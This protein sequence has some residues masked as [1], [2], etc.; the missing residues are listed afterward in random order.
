MS[1]TRRM[2]EKNGTAVVSEYE[3]SEKTRRTKRNPNGSSAILPPANRP[4]NLPALPSTAT[5]DPSGSP[6]RPISVAQR[7]VSTWRRAQRQ[8]VQCVREGGTKRRRRL[9]LTQRLLCRTLGGRMQRTILRRD[10]LHGCTVHAG[11]T[12]N[13]LQG[14]RVPSLWFEAS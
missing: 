14:C 1:R 11:A 5:P 10:T 6:S 12:V 4:S 3:L 8:V 2:N 7:S 9:H 13:M